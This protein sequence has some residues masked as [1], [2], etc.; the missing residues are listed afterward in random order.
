M[1]EDMIRSL[2]PKVCARVL[3][4]LPQQTIF[5]YWNYDSTPRRAE[6]GEALKAKGASDHTEGFDQPKRWAEY[7]KAGFDVLGIP[8]HDWGPIVP[9]YARYTVR[10]TLEMIRNAVRYDGPGIINSHWACF[11]CPLPLQD[12]GIALTADR[13]WKLSNV[14]DVRDFDEAYCRL[15]FGMA[16]RTFLEALYQMDGMLEMPTNLGRGVHLPYWYYMDA[17]L[18]YPNAHAD[19]LK[20]GPDAPPEDVNWRSIVQK[21][22]ALLQKSPVREA[23]V[24]GLERIRDQGAA[25]RHLLAGI[26]HRVRRSRDLLELVE[27]LAA[28]RQHAAERMLALAS[29]RKKTASLLQE[30]R[31]LRQRMRRVYGRFMDPRDYVHEEA[32]LFEG[33]ETLLGGQN[34]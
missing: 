19:R 12:Y 5:C 2:P 17:V 7:R 8:C 10:N 18:H 30:S 25:A 14:P 27:W 6:R 20:Y 16:E 13:A 11:H 22:L 1:W 3:R 23:S 9:Y 31:R 24:R 34:D 26:E 4:R 21:K 29:G 33:E 28:F 32:S 15:K